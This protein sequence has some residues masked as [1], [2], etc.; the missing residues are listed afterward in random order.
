MALSAAAIVL[1][2]LFAITG[3]HGHRRGNAAAWR[4]STEVNAGQYRANLLNE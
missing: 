3:W 4:R 2:T 1:A